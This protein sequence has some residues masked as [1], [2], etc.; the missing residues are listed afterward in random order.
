MNLTRREFFPVAAAAASLLGAEGRLGA[1]AAKQKI[2]L[3]DLMRFEAKGQLTLLH[4]T[5][6]HAQLNPL[7]YREPQVNIGVGSMA[8]KPPHL[9]GNKALAAYGIKPGTLDAY[10]ISSTD[11]DALARE[12]GRV[13]GMDRM[14]SLVAAIRAERGS[15]KV[16]FLD[17]GD[18]LQGSYTSLESRG[19][20]M[21]R[22]GEAL[23]LDATTGHWEFTLGADRVLELYGTK[24][25]PGFTKTQFL[26][27][28]VRDSDFEEPVF[29]GW[30]MYERG[31]ILVGV[32]GQAY[33]YTP[34][35]NPQ[36]MVPKWWF[37]MRRH[38]LARTVAQ[39]RKSGADVVVLLSHCG[40]DVDLKLAKDVPGIDVI[41][42]GHTHDAVPRPVQLGHTLVV[43]SG[44]HGKFLSRLDIEIRSG[45]IHEWNYRLIPVLSDAIPADPALTRLIEEI[46]EPHE[47]ML[48][49]EL[50]R[51]EVS[52]H[53]RGNFGGTLD[54]LICDAML[55]QRDAEISLSPGFRWGGSI[56]AG[57]PISWDDVYDVTAITY[58]NVDRQPILGAFL[59]TMLED[60]A[61]NLF[62]PNPYYQQGGDMVR[63]GGM[64]FTIR[65]NAPMGQRI[66]DLTLLRTAKPIDPNRTYMVAGWGAVNQ[67]IEGPPIWDVFASHLRD[68][69]VVRGEIANNVNVKL[70]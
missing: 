4:M 3:E 44:S 67:G 54:N 23:G 68:M 33:P 49:T 52:L 14:A 7:Y 34:I 37:G 64:G 26:A 53:R 60:V 40:F 19:G 13:G 12:Y 22:V 8:G 25:Q 21:I 43:G 47:A 36:W 61:D 15:N 51:T 29:K 11:F 70:D 56:L 65:P 24:D 9:T 2:G 16:L 66:S 62:N 30:K 48:S 69:Q 5:D 45:G 20:D 27:T 41:L 18:L 39:V 38:A 63:V 35:A 58:P 55:S 31:G 57:D 59:K 42:S 32:I 17:G 1:A 10:A 6:C 50:A 28:N 46:R